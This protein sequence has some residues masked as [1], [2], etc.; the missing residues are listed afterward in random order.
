MG[1]ELFDV[2]GKIGMTKL[3]IV[4]RNFAN[5]TK[6]ESVAKVR[7]EGS[8]K[9]RLLLWSKSTWSQTDFADVTT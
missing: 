1:A 2:E 8:S 5:V 7:S 3:T 9:M 4:F 6:N